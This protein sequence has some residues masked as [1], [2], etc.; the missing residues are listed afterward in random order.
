ME[1]AIKC[2]EDDELLSAEL[3][4]V[5]MKAFCAIKMDEIERWNKFTNDEERWDH[6]RT[7][8]GLYM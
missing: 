7:K 8:F 6:Y 4:E 5:F 2:L 1:E 3:G